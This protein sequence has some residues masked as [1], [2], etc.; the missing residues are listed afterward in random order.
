[1][2][3]YGFYARLPLTLAM[4]KD[5]A[6][7]RMDECPIHGQRFVSRRVMALDCLAGFVGLVIVTDNLLENDWS[8]AII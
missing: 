5:D 7:V 3:N 6:R 1:M 4:E 8:F 2:K